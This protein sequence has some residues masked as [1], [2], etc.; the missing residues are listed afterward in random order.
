M[1]IYICLAQGKRQGCFGPTASH[2]AS[3]GRAAREYMGTHM[4]PYVLGD[5]CKLQCYFW[6]EMVQSSKVK[7]IQI[8]P[9]LNLYVVIDYIWHVSSKDRN[10][11][12]HAIVIAWLAPKNAWVSLSDIRVLGPLMKYIWKKS[13]FHSDSFPQTWRNPSRSWLVSIF[14]QFLILQNMLNYLKLLCKI[15]LTVTILQS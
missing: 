13:C 2:A 15:T 11:L 8:D 12:K 5:S 1:F 6:S 10:P 7:G 14:R 9:I 4:H 3:A